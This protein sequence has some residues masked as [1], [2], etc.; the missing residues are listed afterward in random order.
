MGNLSTFFKESE[1]SL[2][3]FH[4]KDYVIA[5]FPAYSAANS[6]YQAL[7]QAGIAEDE[8]MLCTGKEMLEYF[9]NFREDAGLWGDLM[10][11]LSRFLG[12]E[13]NNADLNIAQA[14]EG[15]GFLAIHCPTEEEALRDMALMKPYNPSSA[16]WYLWGGIRSLI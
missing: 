3:V 13:A 10:R 8:V 11:P 2:G 6:A 4:P 9:K 1:S 5:T 16:D 14:Q 12:A 15:S 7:R